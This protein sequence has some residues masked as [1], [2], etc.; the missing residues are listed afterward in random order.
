MMIRDIEALLKKLS[1]TLMVIGGAVAVLGLSGYSG[2]HIQ[3][4]SDTDRI[5]IAIGVG[6][7]ILGMFFRKQSQ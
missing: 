1:L 3:A 5:E 6:L 7:F 2:T 4:W